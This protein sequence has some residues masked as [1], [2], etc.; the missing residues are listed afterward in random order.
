MATV[1]KKK[2]KPR[3]NNDS[4][5]TIS[6]NTINESVNIADTTIIAEPPKPETSRVEIHD[7]DSFINE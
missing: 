4:I 3:G 6:M 5:S 2:Y 1:I 7:L